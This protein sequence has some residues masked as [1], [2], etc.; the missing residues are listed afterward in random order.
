M[1]LYFQNQFTDTL[2]IAFLYYH[3]EC[4][5]NGGTP[6]RKMGWWGVAPG[7]TFNAWDTDL[8]QVGSH[9]AFYAEEFRDSGGATWSGSG[10]N[11]YRIPDTG[12][13][14][15][16]D[17]NVNCTQQPD[18]ILLEFNQ[19]SDALVILGPD[20]S[21]VQVNEWIPLP[22]RLDFDWSP[23]GFRTGVAAGGWAHLTLHQNGSYLFTGHFHDSGA[24]EYNLSLALA[25]QGGNGLAYT[26]NHSGHVAGTFE[27][28]SRDDDWTNEGQRSELAADWANIVAASRAAGQAAA[29]SDLSNLINAVVGALGTVLG[30]V[31]IVIA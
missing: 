21:Q 23:I 30:I 16:Y 24:I 26:F 13:A 19:Q 5:A 12:F 2:W 28:G 14:Q 4:S 20:P 18:F 7:Q 22:E 17:D 15:C 25:V 11:W 9:A 6:F 10:N 8:R 3:P 27:S 1:A 31:A 29:T